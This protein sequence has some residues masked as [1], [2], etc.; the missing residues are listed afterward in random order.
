MGKCLHQVVDNELAAADEEVAQRLPAVR[1]VERVVL[2][3]PL[4]GQLA[5]RLA[6]LVAQPREL[7]LPGE[8]LLARLDPL[9]VR[10]DLVVG[11]GHSFG[12]CA[13]RSRSISLSDA[14]RRW[15]W[16]CQYLL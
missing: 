6:Q 3:D 10:N 8:E 9:L 15:N 2:G 4:P 12:G 7:L 14:A 11:H 13:S 1:P 5:T 16:A